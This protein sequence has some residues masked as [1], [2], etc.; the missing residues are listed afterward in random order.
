MFVQLNQADGDTAQYFSR[1]CALVRG[2]EKRGLANLRRI[3]E[4]ATALKCFAYAG[5]VIRIDICAP[6]SFPKATFFQK[7]LTD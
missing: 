6:E 7:R 5:L 1:I 4:L 3:L 2:F